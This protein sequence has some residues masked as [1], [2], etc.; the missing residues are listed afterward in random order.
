MITS[1]K[2][3]V[4][5][6][7]TEPKDN[8]AG[9]AVTASL[10]TPVPATFSERVGFGALLVNLTL[11][12]IHPVDSG[13]KLTL[14]STLAPAERTRGKLSE[15][16]TKREELTLMPERVALVV[17]LLVRVTNKVWVW[18]VSTSPKRSVEGEQASCAEAAAAPAGMKPATRS[19]MVKVSEWWKRKECGW[20]FDWGSRIASILRLSAGKKKI[21][22][23][24]QPH[25]KGHQFQIRNGVGD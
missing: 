1:G 18:P 2:V 12:P 24:Q 21:P 22:E 5:P 3:E 25:E 23:V 7:A 15:D 9:L 11:P 17:P 6:A 4:L 14:R 8:V 10:A 19:A 16:V 13:V 20:R